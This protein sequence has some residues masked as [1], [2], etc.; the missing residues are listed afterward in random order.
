VQSGNRRNV[1]FIALLALLGVA[2]MTFHL[3]LGGVLLLLG[4]D[5]LLAPAW[6]IALLAMVAALAHAARLWLWQ[7]WR[8]ARGHTG[9]P[10]VADR[11]EV[12]CYLLV[13]LAAVIRVAGGMLLPGA[14]L[15]TVVVSGLCWSGAFTIYAV[16]YWPVLS[17]N[18][19]DGKAG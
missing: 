13:A 18:R 6:I 9:R 8:T 17:R 4:G 2:V 1:F 11:F 19:L 14:Y 7:P 15:A 5:L 3:A 10:L 16:R 12:T